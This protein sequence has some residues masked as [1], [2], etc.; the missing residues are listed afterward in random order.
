VRQ[1]LAE[2]GQEVFPRDQ[3]TPEV[4]GEIDKWWPMIKAANVRAERG[5]IEVLSSANREEQK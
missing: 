5:R 3:H 4:L 1:R 2:L